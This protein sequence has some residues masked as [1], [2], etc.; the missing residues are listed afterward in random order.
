[1]VVIG[2]FVGWA[3][4]KR[5]NKRPYGE[6]GK[7]LGVLLA[8]GLIVGESLMIVLVGAIVFA[9]SNT[10]PLAA[11]GDDF[12]QTGVI[13]G[14]VAFLALIAGLYAWLGRLAKGTAR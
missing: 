10:S 14:G 5:M 7:R 1:R 8:S 3:F 12:A 13:V 11:V 9:T 4:E 2:A 6:P